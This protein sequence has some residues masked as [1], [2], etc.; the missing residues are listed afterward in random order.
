MGRVVAACDLLSKQLDCTVAAVA[1]PGKDAARGMRG[2]SALLGGLD[3]VI[4]LEK[5]DNGIRTWT[6]EKQKEGE[7]GLTGQFKLHVLAIG[8]DDDGDEITS[9]VILPLDESEIDSNDM[10]AKESEAIARSR[11]LF[12][13]AV[14]AVGRIAYGK[15]FVSA[16]AWN[17]HTKT[18]PFATD[19]SR[20]QA[21]SRAKKILVKEGYIQEVRG[22]YEA[23]DHPA[24]IGAFIGL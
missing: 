13:N 21:L 23:T 6:I 1:H 14:M 18:M 16:D 9:A 24:F 5:D 22:G 17:E 8:E 10:P 12:E 2:G 7:D 4:Q 20:R 11:K 15:P 19:D 3:T